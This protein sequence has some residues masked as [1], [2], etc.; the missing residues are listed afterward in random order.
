ML[1]D[2]SM[3]YDCI[4]M[5]LEKALTL[6]FDQTA[7][8]NQRDFWFTLGYF[9][10]LRLQLPAANGAG[11]NMV[12]R[13]YRDINM[14]SQHTNAKIYTHPLHIISNLAD[15]AKA[16][17]YRRFFEESTPFLCVTFFQC[18]PLLQ[19]SPIQL[20]QEADALLVQTIKA[21]GDDEQRKL[22]YVIY[23]TLN[24]SDFVV[25]WKTNSLQWLLKA[26]Q[27]LHTSDFV[28]DLHSIPAVRYDCLMLF[29]NG[30]SREG[31]RPV[32]EKIDQIITRY[33]VRDSKLASEFFQAL[34]DEIREEPFFSTGVEDVSTV[35]Q[36]VSTQTLFKTLGH[37]LFDQKASAQFHSAFLDCETHLGLSG[38]SSNVAQVQKTDLQDYCERLNQCY[39][40]V[41]NKVISLSEDGLD[42]DWLRTAGNLYHSLLD[43]SRNAVAD[44]FCYLVIDG[45][46][47][48]CSELAKMKEPCDTEQLMRFQRFIRGWG[49]LID[50]T[51]R[52][53]G[54]FAQQP[55]FSPALCPIPSRLLELY[56]AF[57]TQCGK[58]MQSNS[59]DNSRFALLLVPKLC[60]RIKVESVF[61]RI[62]PSDRLLF[63]DVPL[64]I[65]F[66]PFFALAH[67]CH[68]ISHF[69]GESWR[70]REERKRAYLKICARELAN[71][72]D[73]QRED[74]I[75]EMYNALSNYK[76]SPPAYLAIL[77]DQ[78][79]DCLDILIEDRSVVSE[80]IQHAYP[81]EEYDAESYARNIA[82]TT[83]WKGLL[84]SSHINQGNPI[85]RL[86][87]VIQTEYYELFK[88]CY[89]DVS[90]IFTLRLSGVDYMRL[91]QKEIVLS[92]RGSPMMDDYILV[93]ERWTITLHVTHQNDALI[94]IRSDQL[95]QELW[96]FAEDI[97]AC[98][99]Y[100][101]GDAPVVANPSSNYLDYRCV[102][103]LCDYLSNCL[104]MMRDSEQDTESY[105]SKCL[106][107]I[108][109]T[110][111]K[112]T[113]YHDVIGEECWQMI[114]N[115]RSE[116]IQRISSLES[117]LKDYLADT[118]R[119]S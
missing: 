105:Q 7:P 50:Q 48:F 55:G 12:K 47:M 1:S 36:D 88:E 86:Y 17:R 67:L 82:S 64:D 108:R 30:L 87:S 2:A 33:I 58:M 79:L 54:K 61:S 101:F 8:E 59:S 104:R 81:K 39:S 116:T 107:R 26:L 15:G 78:I 115:H 5:K 113:E 95:P 14:Q 89:A 53:D 35:R 10:A 117:T 27:A 4:T 80:W 13:I 51:M 40:I 6:E 43:M 38:Y 84:A 57:T 77:R 71:Q 65:L 41:K 92:N 102:G 42:S 118:D 114:S 63:V 16:E 22:H 103:Y 66:D 112:I 46:A 75:N 52:L 72:L 45:A 9:D 68:E 31:S 3:N 25:L 96:Q 18:S 73:I 83:S 74:V 85:N 24:L 69:C 93:V 97:E 37:R 99:N 106:R 11:E 20:E 91:A 70:L 29:Q 62:P 111:E 34:P 23:Q 100:F 49:S 60:R 94:A 19:K 44:G 76:Y 119:K 109:A 98:Y 32:E 56:L 21:L 90:N 28:G 110:Y